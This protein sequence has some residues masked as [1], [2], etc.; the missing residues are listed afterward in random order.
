M[1]CTV[2]L[3][4]AELTSCQ[5]LHTT[6]PSSTHRNGHRLV[7]THGYA[8]DSPVTLHMLKSTFKAS[9][10]INLVPRLLL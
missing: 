8:I 3:G 6:L 7:P 10:G 9:L 2:P 4:S 1:Y 5:L